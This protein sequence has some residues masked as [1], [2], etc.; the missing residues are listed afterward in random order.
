MQKVTIASLYLEPDY[1]VWYQ[2][3]CDRKKESIIY[4]SIF[5]EAL[6]SHYGDTNIN[7]F[8]SQLVNIKQKGSVTDHIKQFQQLSS[9]SEEYFRR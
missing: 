7:T 1:F 8:F 4:C 9:Q 3:L 2:C 6:I 5:T